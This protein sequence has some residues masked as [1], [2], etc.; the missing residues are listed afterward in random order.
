MR[1]MVELSN[2]PL[3]SFLFSTVAGIPADYFL[4]YEEKS[5][6]LIWRYNVKDKN[7]TVY[8]PSLFEWLALLFIGLRLAGVIAW[9]WLWVL[10]PLWL[11]VCLVIIIACV[12][13]LVGR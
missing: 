11:P 10:A 8:S 13:A 9:P 12:V 1:T 5:Y 7:I 3:W 6:E 4:L 2:S